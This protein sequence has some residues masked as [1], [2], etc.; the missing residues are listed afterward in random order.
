VLLTTP[1]LTHI[2][3]WTRFSNFSD[4]HALSEQEW[5]KLSSPSLVISVRNR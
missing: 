1:R 5:D 4:L 2:Q 3:G